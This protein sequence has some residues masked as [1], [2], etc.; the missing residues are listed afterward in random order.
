MDINKCLTM[1]MFE[2]TVGSYTCQS[3]AVLLEMI[4]A[5]KMFSVSRNFPLCKPGSS[6]TARVS[7][8]ELIVYQAGDASDFFNV[9]NLI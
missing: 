8:Y 7:A 2:N 9:I 4:M 6:V 1:T 5:K 3:E